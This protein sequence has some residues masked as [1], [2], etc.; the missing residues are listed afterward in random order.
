[1]AE[2]TNATSARPVRVRFAPS[3]TGF[4]HI[5]S[6]RTALFNWLYARH[7]GGTFILRIED[8]DKER[9]TEES[10]RVIFEGMR[11]L[12]MDW[13]EGPEVGGDY[14]PYFQS[15]REGIYRDYLKKLADAG[16]AYQKDGAWYFHVPGERYKWYDPYRKVEVEKVKVE[17][18]VY[19]DAVLGRMS[20]MVDEDFV[21]F[22]ANGD[23]VFHFV[24][25]VDDIAMNISHIIRGADHKEN[26]YKHVALFEAFGVPTPVFAHIP[27]I[28]KTS[29]PGKMSK[30]DKGALVEE[31]REKGTLPKALV[32]FLSLLGWNPKNDR[33][34][35][36]I[37]EIVERFD[38]PGINKDNAR[39][40]EKKL[41]HFNTEHMR[42]LEIGSYTWLARPFLE[43]AGLV[44]DNTE[45]TYLQE[46]L[47]LCQEKIRSFDDLPKYTHYFFKEE[48][49]EDAV[50]REKVFKNTPEPLAR[51]A[52]W[53]SVLKTLPDSEWTDAGLEAA[54]Q[55]LCTQTGKQTSEYIHITRLALSGTN[56]GPAFYGLIRV[57]G[58]ER[59]LA[60]IA[61]YK[62]SE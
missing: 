27:L 6:A 51:L 3:P 52:E 36:E 38:L 55:T 26:T 60:R 10:V 13:D 29:G 34:I 24:N 20:H 50:A 54:L 25:V 4:F 19:V 59:V 37:S 58:K 22:R 2:D 15:Q 42:K 21:I 30:R 48:F 43:K 23:P 14:G 62:P 11:W 5:G 57:L 32:N 39:F 8:T 53:A 47:A 18:T 40:D 46:V 12:G 49:G 9:N 41:A 33:E 35:M 61:R 17:P 45:E 7:T 28:L 56:V 16:R 44:T 31:Y 1:M